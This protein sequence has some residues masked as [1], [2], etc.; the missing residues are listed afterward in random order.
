MAKPKA[1]YRVE[2]G[3]SVGGGTMKK[4]TLVKNK[5]NGD[6]GIFIEYRS[7]DHLSRDKVRVRLINPVSIKSG[8]YRLWLQGV[9]VVISES[10]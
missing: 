7:E 1:P 3:L 4:G 10:R 8:L 6:V 2:M 5:Y 9:V